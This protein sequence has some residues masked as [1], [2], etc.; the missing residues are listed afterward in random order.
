MKRKVGVVGLGNMGGGVARNYQKAGLPLAVWDTAEAACRGFEGLAGVD[1]LPPGE[2]AA[3]CGVIIFVVPS[4]PEIAAYFEGDQGILARAAEGLVVYDFTTSDPVATREIAGRAAAR[5]IAY[6]D[7]GM[8]GGAAGADAGT[9]TLMIGGDRSA[10]ESTRGLLAPI[11]KQIFHLGGSGAGHTMKLIHNMVCHTIYLST[12]E[13]GRMAEAAGIDLADMIAVFNVSN[14]R[15][16]AS[17]VRFPRHI[18]SGKWDARSRVY[19]LRKDLSMAVGLAG[20]LEAN[21][22]LGTAV[23][24]FLNAAIAKGMADTDYSR[25]YE[26]FDEIVAAIGDRVR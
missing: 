6:L 19:N 7:A 8:S 24:D 22:P 11:A 20:S 13:G 18:L 15:S 14:A 23:R 3:I 25:L 5:G 4:T 9:L 17:E 21:V 26:R 16:Y 10:F 12:C 1:I 2:M